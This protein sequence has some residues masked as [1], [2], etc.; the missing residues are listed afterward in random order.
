[1][2]FFLGWA[3]TLVAG[4]YELHSKGLELVKSDDQVLQGPEEAVHLHHNHGVN[5]ARAGQL[6]E[7]LQTGPVIPSTGS[8]IHNLVRDRP[9]PRLAVSAQLLDLDFRFFVRGGSY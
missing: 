5:L 9:A 3:A 6:N 7:S 1:V 8:R 4:R 2:C